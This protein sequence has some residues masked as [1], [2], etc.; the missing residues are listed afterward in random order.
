MAGEKCNCNGHGAYPQL[1][2]ILEKY[3][4]S[5]GSIIAILQRAQDAL[6]YLPEGA[7]RYIAE[8]TGVSPAKV[9]GVATFYA[10][11]RLK[12]AGRYQL[13]LCMG[14][15]C[16]VNGAADIAAAVSERLGACDGGTTEDGLFTLNIVACLG[17]CS[18]APVMM[19]RGKDGDEVFG[20]L[21]RASVVRILDRIAADAQAE[22]VGA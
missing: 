15:A 9:Y 14:T 3:A 22:G 2:P 13:M 5:P 7:I 8:R 20:N 19:V 6:G 12:P 21:T 10:Q 18:L 1:E 11:F 4:G 16:H 17:C